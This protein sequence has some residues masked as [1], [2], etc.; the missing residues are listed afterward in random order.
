V[1]LVT[2]ACIIFRVWQVSQGIATQ[3]RPRIIAAMRLTQ[4]PAK[5]NVVLQLLSQSSGDYGTSRT[6]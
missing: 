2:L 6:R 3:T 1:T 4:Q 5:T